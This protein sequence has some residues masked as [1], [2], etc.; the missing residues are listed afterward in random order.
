MRQFT[1]FFARLSVSTRVRTTYDEPVLVEERGTVWKDKSAEGGSLQGG[2]RRSSSNLVEKRGEG[3]VEKGDVQIV[4][5]PKKERLLKKISQNKSVL[6]ANRSAKKFSENDL[7]RTNLILSSEK[8][9]K[10]SDSPKLWA[11]LSICWGS[12]AQVWEVNKMHEFCHNL[13]F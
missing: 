7:D 2:S 12:N 5:I 6:G 3:E 1:I 9:T 8:R 4:Q 13:T 11:S 10:G